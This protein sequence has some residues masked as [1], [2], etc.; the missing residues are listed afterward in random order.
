MNRLS[1][2]AVPV[3]LILPSLVLAIFI[4]AYPFYDL[5]QI[6]LQDVTRF[7]TLQGFNGFA[8]FA[9]VLADPEFLASLWRTV[10]WTGSVVAGTIIVSLPVALILNEDFIGRGVAR[11]IVMLPWSVSLTMTAIVWR[12]ALNGDYGLLNATLQ[13]L[14]LIA[15]PIIWLA[16]S[17][18]AFPMEILVGILVSIPF[19]VTIF[20]GGLSS[21]PSDVYEAA[22]IDG[23]TRWQQFTRLTLPLIRPFVNMAIVL[24]I[25]Y[26]F[27]S[28]PII[29]VLTEG[30]PA[31]STDVLVTYLYKLAFRFGRLGDAAA[32]S[33]IMLAIL[34][35]FTTIY[36]RMQMRGETE[37]AEA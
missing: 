13:Q 10:V 3:L 12:W 37:P 28:F 11:T 17:D 8:N 18:T 6:S 14:G 4:I 29:W 20:L 26:V 5:V 9:S 22:R 2:S 16:S 33:V 30:G 25:I 34:M 1:R 7:G 36:V 32:M 21:V 23:A 24:N 15:K 19:T 35:V 27:N 31:N